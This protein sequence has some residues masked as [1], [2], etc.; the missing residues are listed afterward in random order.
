M[1]LLPLLPVGAA[2]FT[3]PSDTGAVTGLRVRCTGF[4]QSGWPRPQL[5]VRGCFPRRWRQRSSLFLLWRISLSGIQLDESAPCGK[6]LNTSSTG[7]K[8][9]VGILLLSGEEIF[10]LYQWFYILL[11]QMNR[12]LIYYRKSML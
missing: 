11:F 10:P 12:H 3:P 8:F 4:R 7:S 2:A 5:L 1:F 9:W 6:N